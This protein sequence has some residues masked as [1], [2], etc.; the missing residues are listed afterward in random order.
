MS[1][2]VAAISKSEYRKQRLDGI[3]YSLERKE[4]LDKNAKLRPNS[5][6]S[7]IN[8]AILPFSTINYSKDQLDALIELG[9]K[10][11]NILPKPEDPSL[12][13]PDFQEF[14]NNMV[15]CVLEEIK[16]NDYS[17]IKEKDL[18]AIV[19]NTSLPENEIPTPSY[20]MLNISLVSSRKNAVFSLQD[21]RLCSSHK[22][23]KRLVYNGERGKEL[24]DCSTSAISL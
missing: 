2:R 10:I 3:E 16:P 4:A 15:K 11:S 23:N 8:K 1:R 17:E 9:R 7:M 24:F 18:E 20:D 12:V 21:L 19:F 13:P 6:T 22:G 14:V 5:I